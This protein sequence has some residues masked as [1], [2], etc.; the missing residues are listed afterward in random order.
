M[1]SPNQNVMGNG[2]RVNVWLTKL[3]VH[4]YLSDKAITKDVDKLLLK[5]DI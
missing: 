1:L 4:K 3:F 2:K 5:G